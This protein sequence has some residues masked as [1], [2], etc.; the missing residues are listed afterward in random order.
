MT[1][2]LR[3]PF[4]C[5]TGE[6]ALPSTPGERA[7]PLINEHLCWGNELHGACV[8]STCQQ[9]AATQEPHASALTWQQVT[10][11][12]LE[13]PGHR[14]KQLLRRPSTHLCAVPRCQCGLR[15][16]QSPC[17][18]HRGSSIS[19]RPAATLWRRQGRPGNEPPV[20]RRTRRTRTSSGRQPATGVGQ[21]GPLQRSC[22]PQLTGPAVPPPGGP[23]RAAAA[24]GRAAQCCSSSD[25]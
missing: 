25:T 6:D 18:R 23:A 16:L 3:P 11:V 1:I 21:V 2:P 12:P 17:S 13:C 20:A 10:E 22:D 8:F 19:E 24:A 5:W 15:K 14:G 4:A 9:H 7:A